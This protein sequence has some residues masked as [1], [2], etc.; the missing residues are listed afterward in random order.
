MQ[1]AT[2]SAIWAKSAKPD[3]KVG[4]SLVAHT[5][6]VVSRLYDFSKIYPQL[7][8]VTDQPEF[9]QQAY[10]ACVLHDFGKAA[11]GFQQQL[12][13]NSR[14]W[15]HR[16]EV[17]S[18]AFV[19]WILPELD[20]EWLAW[21]SAGIVSHHKDLEVITR[22]YPFLDDD[23]EAI[24]QLP[25]DISIENINALAKFVEDDLGSWNQRWQFPGTQIKSQLSADPSTDFFEHAEKRI[26]KN[27]T[28]VALLKRRLKREDSKLRL[29]GIAYAR[30]SHAKRP[31]RLCSRQT[32][33][34]RIYL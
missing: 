8:I 16:H 33:C 19:Q 12:R 15:G 5:A 21:I 28:M 23:I 27:L 25:T 32:E 17:L 18:L 1:D 24:A 30:N 3:G 22:R 31:H 29:A 7:H 2:L 9:W 26:R 11:S 34:L 13:E 10:W 14:S 6:N 4:E 20:D